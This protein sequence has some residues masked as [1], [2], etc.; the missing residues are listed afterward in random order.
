MATLTLHGD[1]LRLRFTRTEK[2]LG[3]VRDHDFPRRAV[4]SARVA[5][6]GLGA[7]RGLRAPGL[8]VPGHRKVGTWRS[9]SGGRWRRA[10]V[11]VRR[12]APAVVVELD[13]QRFDALVVAVGD[14]TARTLVTELGART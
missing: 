5:D 1:T 6:D 14:V 2:V 3:L 7:V 12:A 9:R 10:L 11:S 4:V 13:D 8:G